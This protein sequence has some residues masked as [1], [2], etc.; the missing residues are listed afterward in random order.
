MIFKSEGK[1]SRKR[2]WLY[3]IL[4]VPLVIIVVEELFAKKAE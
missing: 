4:L 3:K 2:N 1:V